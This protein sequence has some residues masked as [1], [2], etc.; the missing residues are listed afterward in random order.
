MGFLQ[1]QEFVRQEEDSVQQVEIN[2]ATFYS[3]Q[4]SE[5]NSY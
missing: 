3:R 5:S 2:G 1:G 4:D